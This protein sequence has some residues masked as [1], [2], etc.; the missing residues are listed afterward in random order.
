M[1]LKKRE[2]KM[3][4]GLGIV[5]VVSGIILYR[6]FNP[7]PDELIEK[8]ATTDKTTTTTATTSS[9]GG[10]SR[11]GSSRG[12]GSSSGESTG[13]SVSSSEFQKH[14]TAKDCWVIM[15]DTVYDVTN[16]ITEYSQ[17][18]QGITQY[19][20][21]FGFQSGFLAENSDLRLIIESRASNKGGIK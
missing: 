3:L 7:A 19:C 11:G 20:G 18:A 5:A 14:A 13:P 4:I 16:V 21:T 10:G 6:T 9:R 2:K 12:G 1:A 8:I 15:G 17:Y